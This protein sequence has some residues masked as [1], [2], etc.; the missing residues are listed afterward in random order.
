[1]GSECFDQL[2]YA[3]KHLLNV[4]CRKTH[5]ESDDEFLNNSYVCSFCADE[6]R[7]NKDVAQS[8]FNHLS[9][10]PKHLRALR[11]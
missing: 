11:S 5:N 2:K 7:G 3:V 6:L 1:M 8:A 9:V 10:I 4:I